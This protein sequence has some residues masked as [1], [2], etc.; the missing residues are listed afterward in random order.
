MSRTQ[1]HS[2]A[3]SIMSVNIRS[4]VIGNPSRDLPAC[5]AVSQP[6]RETEGR[7]ITVDVRSCTHMTC[8]IIS[9]YLRAEQVTLTYFRLF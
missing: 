8:L 2:T 3:G 6:P 7:L 5:S 1:D 9:L 4:D